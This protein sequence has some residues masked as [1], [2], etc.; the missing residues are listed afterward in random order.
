M[1]LS[2]YSRFIKSFD[3]TLFGSVVLLLLFGLSALYSLESSAE[4]PDFANFK[5][6]VAYIIVGLIVAAIAMS[7]DYRVWESFSYWWYGATAALLVGVLLF[8]RTIR[9]TTG[10]FSL[11][12]FSFQ[13]VE[14]AKIGLIV[15]LAWFFSRRPDGGR[16]ISSFYQSGAFA[17]GLFALVIAQPD[18]GS[19]ILLI[20]IWLVLAILSGADLRQVALLAGFGILAGIIAWVF[21]FE[22][23][24]HDRI[25]TFFNP[26]S[27]PY[28]SGYHVRQ[29]VTAVGA[30]GFLGRGLG[31]GSQSQLKFLPASETDFIFA[32]LAEELGF[33]GVSLILFFWGL[34]FYRLY[35]AVQQVR[36]PFAATFI[37][38]VTTLF[39]FH[40][41]IN[42][43]MNMG[44]VPVT[45]ISLPFLS[46]GG[47][48]IV[49][50]LLAFGLVEGM[51]IRNRIT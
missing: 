21:L 33:I 2:R 29:S 40:L 16:S 41:M 6:Q 18:F 50:S 47:S 4:Q 43:G 8:G 30:G 1:F 44:L 36:D 42:I 27:D 17:V 46:Y 7:F 26:Q 25:L 20:G 14:L 3:W 35:R 23:Y 48:F 12:G 32:V 37:L 31:F 13:P 39:F 19:G 10:W 34:I 15:A 51:I 5:K 49:T 9:G 45:G 24:Q 28:G 11:A 38:G 22:P